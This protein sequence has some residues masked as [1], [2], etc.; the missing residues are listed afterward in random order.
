MRASCRYLPAVFALGV[1]CWS[2]MAG[3][4]KTRQKKT[5]DAAGTLMRQ[6]LNHSQKVLE[7]VATA[8]FRMIS[9]SA[10]ELIQLTKAEEWQVLRTARYQ[11]FSDEFRRT[12]EDL[13]AKADSK[14]L[15]GAALAYVEMT[16]SCV[17]CHR[18]VREVREARRENKALYE[19]VL[20]KYLP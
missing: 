12:A 1:L 19:T 14:N 4:E 7:G 11:L 13:A 6:K 10:E 2:A 17:R 8:N 3:Q 18:Y 16:L 9:R 15:D 5:P 20:A